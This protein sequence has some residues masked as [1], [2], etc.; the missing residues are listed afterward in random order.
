MYTFVIDYNKSPQP[1]INAGKTD[2]LLKCGKAAIF[3]RFPFTIILKNVIERV[4]FPKFILKIDPGSKTTGLSI[5]EKIDGKDLVIWAA[6]LIHRREWIVKKMKSRGDVRRSR[7]SRKTPYR[8]ARFLNRR[9][10]PDWLPPSTESVVSNIVTWADRIC[11]ACPIT[12]VYLESNVFDPQKELNIDIK[13]KKPK[14]KNKRDK[15]IKAESCCFYCKKT[16][17]ELRKEGLELNKDHYISKKNGGTDSFR[18]YVLSC[19]PCNEK[20]GGLNGNEYLI[21]DVKTVVSL[22][23]MAV[24]NQIRYVLPQRIADKTNRNVSCFECVFTVENR[25]KF[26]GSKEFKENNREFFHWIDASC[27]GYV[28]DLIFKINKVLIIESKG[29]GSRQMCQVD[30]SGFPKSVPRS[31]QKKVHGI[32][33]GDMV[34]DNQNK[35]VPVVGVRKTGQMSLRGDEKD[36]NRTHNKLKVIQHADGYIYRSQDISVLLASIYSSTKT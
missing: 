33:T 32:Q 16:K 19:R 12:E 3:K 27:V 5:V 14:Y 18:N 17:E 8:K 2:E 4:N 26:I 30:K 10:K 35:I 29:H 11:K 25:E 7:R 31:R 22:S 6:Q 28:N 21:S 15:L 9:R 24:M 1:P 36:Y 20:K 13:T 23:S 34:I